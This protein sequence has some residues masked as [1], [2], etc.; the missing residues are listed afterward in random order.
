MK[1][2]VSI[3]TKR[4]EMYK[5]INSI[6]LF[7]V[8][9]IRFLFQDPYMWAKKGYATN[10]PFWLPMEKPI[11]YSYSSPFSCL[12]SVSVTT[13]ILPGTQTDIQFTGARRKTNIQNIHRWD[14]NEI[15]LIYTKFYH[16]LSMFC[17]AWW[18]ITEVDVML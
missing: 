14:L 5:K 4:F 17:C 6:L 12:F 13:T 18:K 2:I 7:D 15:Q 10:E 16:L 11:N 3:K 9:S 8:I 1:I